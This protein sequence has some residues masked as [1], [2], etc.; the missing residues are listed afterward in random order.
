MQSIKFAKILSM[1]S[2]FLQPVD[3]RIINDYYAT[4]PYI[5]DYIHLYHEKKSL[6]NYTI[7]SGC[8]GSMN[9]FK[10]V[11]EIANADAALAASIFHFREISI[12]ELKQYLQEQNI[13]VRL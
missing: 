12:Q 13:P 1:I 8:S 4:N 6:E 5:S 11:F 9:H 10:D 3:Q 7:A 2:D